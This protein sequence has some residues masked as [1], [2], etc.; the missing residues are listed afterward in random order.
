MTIRFDDRVAVVTGAGTGLGR[1]HALLLASRGA[2]VVVNDTGGGV[3]GRGSAKAVAERVVA[4]I[5]DAGGEA[6]AS[7]DSVATPEGAAA[8]VQTAI[9]TWGRIDIL[10]NNA[11]MLRDK[12]FPKMTLEDYRDIVDVHFLGSMYTVRAAWPHM[13]ERGY[14][15]I[16][17]TTSVAGTNGNFGQTNYGA[18]KM[19]V[20]GLMNCLAIE[21]R[22]NGILCNAISPGAMTR[23]TEGLIPEDIGRHHHPE[24]V[25]PAVAWLCSERCEE[26]ATVIQASAGGYSRLQYFQTEGVQFDPR[27]TVT[28]DDFD[29]AFARINDLSTATPSLLG[30]LGNAGERLKALGLV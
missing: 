8:I 24:L 26:T 6:V 12:S 30:E 25:S 4:E 15:R 2:K 9:D 18:A 23:M 27:E 13:K 10:V 3:D 17:M 11:G 28:V 19:A 22:K 29:A 7:H 1:C 14:G 20:L 5:R 21:G 16:V